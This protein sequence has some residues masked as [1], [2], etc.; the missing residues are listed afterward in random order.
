MSE[1][2]EKLTDEDILIEA[3]GEFFDKSAGPKVSAYQHS[4]IGGV[5]E[6]DGSVIAVFAFRVPADMGQAVNT[7]IRKLV[8]DVDGTL[9]IDK[10]ELLRPEK[11]N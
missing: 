2:D 6:E 4:V 3:V 1:S 10:P 9:N 5:D 7:L 11:L 8:E